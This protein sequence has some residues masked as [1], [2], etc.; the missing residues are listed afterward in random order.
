M[1]DEDQR[2]WYSTPAGTAESEVQLAGTTPDRRTDVQVPERHEYGSAVPCVSRARRYSPATCH[3][4]R[5]DQM[6]DETSHPRRI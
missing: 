4:Q 5:G 6:I 1:K 2:D 3:E